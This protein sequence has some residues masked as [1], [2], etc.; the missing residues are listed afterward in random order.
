MSIALR[1]SGL[2]FLV[3]IL[4]ALAT[5]GWWTFADRPQTW[6]IANW[7][8]AGL[9][10]PPSADNAAIYVLA[11]RTGGLKG[12][13]SVHSWI[14]LKRPGETSYE[15]YDKVGWGSPIRRNHRDADGYWYSNPPYVVHAVEG[16]AAERLLPQFDSAIAAYPYSQP[17]GYRIWPG[18]NSNSFVANVLDAV[19]DF[20]GRLPSNAV[21]R[22][23]VAGLGAFGLTPDRR[24]FRINLG[25]YAGVTIG[26]SSGIEFHLLGLVAGIDIQRW[27]IKVPGYGTVSLY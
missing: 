7:S 17:G 2:V 11:A 5:L 12:A 22:D 24:D 23:Y 13:L 9:L 8:S 20:G 18:P 1:L 3:F 27:G 25:G 6:R 10:P 15:R 14:V 21:G 26:A 16:E 4:P 19:P